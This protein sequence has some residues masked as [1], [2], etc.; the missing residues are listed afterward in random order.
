MVGGD[1][2]PSLLRFSKQFAI[3]LIFSLCVGVTGVLTTTTTAFAMEN[4]SP[5]SVPQ[6]QPQ[7]QG[8]KLQQ[9]EA[10]TEQLYQYMQ[11]GNVSKSQ[12]Q[13]SIVVEMVKSISF[14]QLTSIEGIHELAGAIM[15]VQQVIVSVSISE[16]EWQRSSA[17]LRLAVNSM[18]HHK[19]GLWLNYYKVMTEQFKSMNLAQTNGDKDKLQAAILHLNE[20]YQL[21]RPAAVIVRDASTISQFDS[22][23]SYASKLSQQSQP[24]WE[25]WKGLLSQGE[26]ALNQLFGKATHDPVFLP[27]IYNQHPWR[28]VMLIGGWILLSLLYTAWRKYKGEQDHIVTLP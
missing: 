11:S 25:V 26:L 18:L 6:L 17:S 3:V 21:I 27:I 24:N 5:Q 28:L 20:N 22:W 9:L 15:D 2:M 16:E 4:K 1:H 12:E 8:Q 10:A 14:K 7:Q 23:M 19:A 13:L